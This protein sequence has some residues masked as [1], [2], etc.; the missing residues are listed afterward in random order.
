MELRG[1]SII[2]R[3]DAGTLRES[4]LALSI[5]KAQCAQCFVTCMLVPF[6][7]RIKLE[8]LIKRFVNLMYGIQLVCIPVFSFEFLLS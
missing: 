2:S 7:L 8:L 3:S 4:K 6:E 5:C 1:A